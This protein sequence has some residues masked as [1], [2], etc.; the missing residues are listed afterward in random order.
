[1]SNQPL[2]PLG[3]TVATPGA[4]EALDSADETAIELFLRHQSGDWGGT[5]DPEDVAA[6]DQ[7]VKEGGR[8]LSAYIL[9]N[10]TKVWIIT[11]WDRSVSTILLP[12]EY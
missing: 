1:M 11:E 9:S 8:I 4:I 10:D 6:N 7:A 2:F 3:K 12:S 5:L